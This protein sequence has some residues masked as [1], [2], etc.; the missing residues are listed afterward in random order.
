MQGMMF[1]RVNVR[2]KVFNYDKKP[3]GWLKGVKSVN[4]SCVDHNYWF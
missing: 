2:N 4:W 1:R 3:C